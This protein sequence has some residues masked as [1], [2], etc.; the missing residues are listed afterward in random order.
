MFYSLKTLNVHNE[1]YL[2]SITQINTPQNRASHVSA[3]DVAQQLY[4]PGSDTMTPLPSETLTSQ[5][6]E[7]MPTQPSV[8][9]TMQPQVSLTTNPPPPSAETFS[10]WDQDPDILQP[11]SDIKIIPM[12]SVSLISNC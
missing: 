9:M 1:M 12:N 3:M 8:T 10:A 2:N 7:M 11:R 6:S 5:P 4:K